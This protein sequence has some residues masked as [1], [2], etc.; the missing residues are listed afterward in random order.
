ML[1]MTIFALQ[2]KN[3][4]Q[5]VSFNMKTTQKYTHVP[6]PTPSHQYTMHMWRLYFDN[7]IAATFTPATTTTTSITYTSR[8]LGPIF[9]E[10]K[11]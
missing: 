8:I 4:F 3:L 11:K 5:N 7:T 6:A 9:R 1:G 10:N 2:V